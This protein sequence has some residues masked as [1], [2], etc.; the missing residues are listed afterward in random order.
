MN[1]KGKGEN[2]K[3]IIGLALAAIMLASVF[4]GIS[5]SAVADNNSSNES[6]DDS[7]VVESQVEEEAV[8]VSAAHGSVTVV[9]DPASPK[10]NIANETQNYTEILRVNFTADKEDVNITKLWIKNDGDIPLT[11]LLIV[12]VNDTGGILAQTS[13]TTAEVELDLQYGIPLGE[14]LKDLRIWVNTSDFTLGKSI[15]LN[16]TKCEARGLASGDTFD[17]TR[18]TPE[19][20]SY[21]IYGA[22]RLN[23]TAGA[24]DTAVG[25]HDA[26]ENTSGVVI[27]QINFTSEIEGCT[28]H[29]VTL[30]WNGTAN[31]T[32]DIST[33]YLVNDTDEDGAW[34]KT[35]AADEPIITTPIGFT[36][37]TVTLELTS[38]ARVD[39]GALDLDKSKN[40]LVVVNTTERFWSNET[41][42]VNVT[43]F[44]AMGAVSTEL[45]GSYAEGQL[46]DNNPLQSNVT[47][48]QARI[49][50]E[51]GENQPNFEFIKARVNNSIVENMQVKFTAIAGKVNLTHITVE[52]QGE[53]EC[54]YTYP[55][56]YWDK[57][58]DGNITSIDALL[59]TTATNFSAV[60]KL[61]NVSLTPAGNLTIGYENETWC[62][63]NE[64]GYTASKYV[65][66][67][68]N[69]TDMFTKDNKTE[70]VVNTTA[71]YG[72]WSNYTAYDTV[73][74]REI[75]NSN[76]VTIEAVELGAVD[77]AGKIKVAKGSNQP[78][79][80]VGLGEKLVPV[81]QLNFTWEPETVTMKEATIDFITI[82]A[83]GTAIEKDNNVTLGLL[84]DENGDGI[85]D[86]DET[87]ISDM[88]TFDV[89]NGSVKLTPVDLKFGPVSVGTVVYKNILVVANL[90]TA[91]NISDPESNTLWFNMT[92][93][94]I[95]YGAKNNIDVALINETSV[96]I[97]GKKLYPTGSIDAEIGANT[98]EAANI[99][100][101][102]NSTYLILEQINFTATSEDVNVTGVTITW[103]GTGTG[104]EKTSSV[105]IIND[106]DGDGEYNTTAGDTVLNSTVFL[107]NGNKT[108]IG[109]SD[110]NVTLMSFDNFTSDQKWTDED[111]LSV[112]KPT[113]IHIINLINTSV[114]PW[115][116]NV[117][118]NYT[119]ATGQPNQTYFNITPG[120]CPVNDSWNTTTI[121]DNATDFKNIT[122]VSSENV[123]ACTLEI[124]ETITPP[125]ITNNITVA[126]G[127]GTSS[128]LVYVDTSEAGLSSGDKVAVKMS[129]P[130]TDYEAYGVNSGKKVTDYRTTEI[131]S[132]VMSAR[133]SGSLRAY[134][135]PINVTATLRDQIVGKEAQKNITLLGLNFT[136][137]TGED[138][139]INWIKV[140]ANGTVYEKNNITNL[141]LITDT[142]TFGT[143]EE[144]KDEIIPVENEPVNI[145]A[146]NGTATLTPATPIIVEGATS[147]Y[148]LVIADT[149]GAFEPGQLLNL[150][151]ENPKLDYNATGTISGVRVQDTN[152]SAIANT[153]YIT[154]NITIIDY[155]ANNTATGPIT[156]MGV[157]A[158]NNT[159]ILQLNFSASYE[160]INITAI[161]VTWLGSENATNNITVVAYND[162]N[163]TIA[164]DGKWD[165]NDTRLGEAFFVNGT[166]NVP[167]SDT[168]LT[169]PSGN[170]TNMLI[171]LNVTDGYNFTIGDELK[172]NVTNYVAVG[173][174]SE[175]AITPVYG[176]PKESNT[177]TGTGN[178]TVVSTGTPADANIL[179]GVNT[180]V[181]VWLFNMST[182]H[183][184]ATL[185]NITLW[186]N[187]TNAADIAKVDLYNDT[188]AN[189]TVDGNETIIATNGT[190]ISTDGK[191]ILN[192]TKTIYINETPNVQSFLVTVN[193]TSSFKDNHTIGFNI[194]KNSS[195]DV[196]ATGVVSK[197]VMA[198]NYTV[199]MNSSILTGYGSVDL[200]LGADQPNIDN[201]TTGNKSVMAL[202]FNAPLGKIEIL[203]ITVN[204]TGTAG[205]GRLA[206]ISVWKETD[207]DDKFTEADTCYNYTAFDTGNKTL[208]TST[209]TYG[210]LIVENITTV[211]I[212]VNIS[213]ALNGT[214]TLEF[215]VNQTLGVGYNAT[216]NETGLTPY[217]TMNIT[218]P[219]E[220][221]TGNI[222]VTTPPA[223]VSE[224]GLDTNWNL[225]SLWLI[226][227]NTST[228]AVTTDIAS[229][230]Y[231]VYYYDAS[232]GTWKSYFP[233]HGVSGSSLKTMTAGWGY[234]VN[235]TAADTLP[236]SGS[237][238]PSGDVTPPSYPVYTG[239]N[240]IGFHS[241][242]A[243]TNAST[244]FGTQ[245]TDWQSIF[246]WNNAT[247][248]YDTVRPT[249]TLNKGEGY[250]LAA[251]KDYTVY[252][253]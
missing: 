33:I 185:E 24:N 160:A 115:H 51:R 246:K 171:C 54:N 190:A 11:D 141:R 108:T 133:Y 220:V 128:I 82:S 177:L 155:G 218:T 123:S 250:W 202:S 186:F 2:K 138:M 126:K 175:K 201:T 125:Q 90:T 40:Y 101:E 71:T 149:K 169:V 239:W 100:S 129:K 102:V 19:P 52:Q 130:Y 221:I 121:T 83:N 227:D 151:L 57:D 167:F 224:I 4:A 49:I 132:K 46:I 124:I 240:L 12:G 223:A 88:K 207:A 59:N 25:F 99:T 70:V 56:I 67:A 219:G 159:A 210:N 106:T 119:N 191:V 147:K 231:G 172:I 204:Y 146:S 41:L 114:T 116:F 162:T 10:R 103:N 64:S 164:D 9:R 30:E 189:A 7:V 34:N 48:G 105:G 233:E 216:C 29:N 21:T 81:L 3:A 232:A 80:N 120:M 215:K 150:S 187:G 139:Q 75:N 98:P 110:Y 15:I 96:T 234:W 168:N 153:T 145:T 173:N 206:N 92:D 8:S 6:V 198:T 236:V 195:A 192:L 140:T 61:V 18:G 1:T 158:H 69:T 58:N 13:F 142:E 253:M 178:I 230:L 87:L 22:G 117:S 237:F 148:L 135:M 32:D 196:R 203:N 91:L 74:N 85:R 107:V 68:V 42:A 156:A 213:T 95:D 84:Y 14:T 157:V 66:L 78:T 97:A 23:V 109:G 55:K 136:A 111:W 17:C 166:A 245:G 247:D 27:Q 193:T 137:G 235:M 26:G 188:N 180:T 28:I 72:N 248:S 127:A 249:E 176:T 79:A 16:L 38:D 144:D 212:V 76:D 251:L 89:K 241:E 152:E 197:I 131:P 214:D 181:P 200:E 113:V 225:I 252:P 194:T 77:D 43:G 73:L 143:Y 37:D 226:P 60:S 205:T 20:K 134:G 242:N 35:A 199:P 50:I 104:S 53:V 174:T 208:N 211:Y 183:E 154:G 165:V 238:L 86:V 222:S 179:A 170:S 47:N 44:N 31:T 122:Y 182:N 62:Y 229:N 36:D 243:T 217:S 45:M 5:A 118:M 63:E 161:N 112:G 65:I 209:A 94:E 244:Y 163:G 228:D 184:N 93:S 39:E